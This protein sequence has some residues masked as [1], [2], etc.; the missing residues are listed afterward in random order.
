MA[1]PRYDR[2]VQQSLLDRLI[3]TEP[4]NR[5]EVSLSRVESLRRFRLAVKRDLE[6]LLNTTRSEIDIPDSCPLA[7]KSVIT[8]GLQDISNIS[9]NSFTDEQKLL[10]SL[11]ESILAFE[12]RLSRARVTATE[13]LSASKHAVKF[14]VE[15]I[16]MVDPAPERIAFDTVLEIAK[17]AYTVKEA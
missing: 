1:D 12:P 4:E 13:S 17:G 9:L 16:L 10:R 8:Y 11:E 15:A 14:H 6:S 5:R 7:K 3:D 2:T